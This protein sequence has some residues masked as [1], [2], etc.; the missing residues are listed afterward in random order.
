M[1]KQ[2][3]YTHKERYGSPRIYKELKK[4]GVKC[5]KTRIEILMREHGLRARGKKKFKATTN[6]KHNLAV[7][8]NLLNRDFKPD[9]PN[10]I[11]TGDITYIHTREGW[12]YLAVVLDL[13]SRKVIGWAM[14]KRM[15]KA[16]VVNALRMAIGNRSPSRGLIFHSDRGSQ[17]ASTQ[18][19]NI[20]ANHGF[21]QSMSRKGDCWDNSPT[22]SFFATLKKELTRDNNYYSREYA[23]NK[24]FYYIQAYY[25]S[26][27][28]HSF[29]DSLSP[30][31][32]E[33]LAA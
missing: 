20:V 7:F 25:N 9:K 32:Y 22:E 27:R 26:I 23:M 31:E 3:F 1:I 18:F 12:L 6:S 8:P 5:S 2:I 10:K 29:I 21:L 30:V 15:N 13:F 33:R 14:N 11:W 16:L 4:Q 19:K 28:Q 24:I 17:Y